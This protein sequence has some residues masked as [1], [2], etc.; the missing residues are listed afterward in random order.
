VDRRRIP[1]LVAELVSAGFNPAKELRR[2][3]ADEDAAE[4]RERLHHL[5]AEAR[6]QRDDPLARAHQ[7]DTQPE[8]LRP[9]PGSSAAAGAARHKRRAEGPPR[10]S[11]A[12]IRAIIDR[13]IHQGLWLEMI[14][15]SAKDQ[16]R[17]TLLVVPERV[18]LNREGAQVL[19]ATDT[20]QN[21]K[22]SYALAQI[23]RARS[24]EPRAGVVAG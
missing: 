16:A 5:L 21:V 6:E 17:R 24:T 15:V 7:A 11:P 19:V 23:E 12:E 8:D 10:A 3:P 20:A 2:Y 4:A 18:A 22:L 1:E 13:A 14:Y 9:V